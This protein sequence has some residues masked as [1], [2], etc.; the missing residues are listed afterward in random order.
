MNY[1]AILKLTNV[2]AKI[3]VFNNVSKLKLKRRI[4]ESNSF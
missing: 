4:Y 3:D 2:I 1:A